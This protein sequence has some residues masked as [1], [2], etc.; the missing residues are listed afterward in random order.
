MPRII[1]AMSGQG[2]TSI[3][4]DRLGWLQRTGYLK[5]RTLFLDL[6]HLIN[7]SRA[8][9]GVYWELREALRQGVD[10]GEIVCPVSPS[11]LMEVRKQ[12]QTDGRYKCSVLMDQLSGRLSL[13]EA[14]AIFAQ[15]FRAQ[16]LGQQ[17]ERQMVYSFFLDAMSPSGWSLDFP[18][19]AWEPG[20]VG[21]AARMAFDRFASIS[22]PQAINLS[23][24]EQRER[25]MNPLRQ[26]WSTLAQQAGEWRAQNE[27]A[28]SREIEQA[29]FTATVRSRT[30]QIA[31]VLMEPGLA[32]ILE[33]QHGLSGKP[34][35]ERHDEL[36]DILDSCP[37]FWCKYKLLA[38]VRSSRQ[39]LSENDL[40]D[41]QHVASA[42]P[43]VDCL[44][45]DRATRHICTQEV[46]IDRRYD[47][48]IVARPSE[49]LAWVRN[50]AS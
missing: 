30:P 40:W 20:S 47:T 46:G 3:D 10:A 27:Q 31:Q 32:V 2:S 8:R 7:L 5:R 26:G 28:T 15:E 9:D 12:R 33:N 19:P 42:A 24:E 34:D 14:S 38:A 1:T 45:C 29:E 22:I 18:G 36:K 35:D 48:A 13:R 25:N 50:G 17:V 6:N 16:I 23:T 41:L 21:Q 43:Y 44:A 39:T 11:L 37:S 49:I 4:F